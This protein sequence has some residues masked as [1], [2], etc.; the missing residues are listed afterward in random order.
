M[1]RTVS[2]FG[3][4]SGNTA[5]K[6]GPRLSPPV[7]FARAKM[8]SIISSVSFP[9][10]VFCCET[11]KQPRSVYGPELDLGAVAETRLRARAVDARWPRARAARRPSRRTPSATSTR[12]RFSSSSSRSRNGRHSSR[13]AGVG[14]F[15]GGGQRLTA[16]THASR[17]R[18][19]SSTLDRGR[20]VGEPRAVERRVEEVARAIAREDAAGAVRPVR[21]RRQAD[22]RDPR[23]R[24]AEARD[25]PPP[26][27]LAAKALGRVGGD[28]PLATRP[29]AG[30]AGRNGSPRRAS[31]ACRPR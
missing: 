18:R 25:R 24:V 21:R 23:P 17:R 2:A 29:G 5:A 30:S 16:V 7:C 8:P 14:L 22:Y 13:S 28:L 26:V 4:L 12:T 6:Y 1:R 3:R 20:L 15:A 19:P 9:V 11:W 27:A 10:N 31:R